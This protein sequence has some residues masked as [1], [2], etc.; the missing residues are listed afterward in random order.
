MLLKATTIA[1]LPA[2]IIQGLRVKKNT[3]RLDEPQGERQ[4]H[5]GAGQPLSL[6]IVGDSAAAGVGV[7][8]QSDALLGGILNELQYEFQI[9]YTLHAKTGHTSAQVIEALHELTAQHYDVVVT[10]VGV[11][12]VTQLM[13]AG[14]WMKKQHQL[15]RIIEEKFSPSLIIAAGVPPMNHFPALPNPLA[16]LFGQYAK[17]MNQQLAKFV[18]GRANMQW[19]EYDIQKYQAL[20]L[21]M[22][23]DGFHP[24]KEVYQ[25]WAQQVAALIRQKIESSL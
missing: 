9:R 23:Q 8:H 12:D 11:N 18:V 14:R 22:A 24:S 7:Q 2:L 13:S 16:W 5:T 21:A 3:L 17:K 1:L 6:L 10:S 15:Y 20:N 4:G 19:I 25:I